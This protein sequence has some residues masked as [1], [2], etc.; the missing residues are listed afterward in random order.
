M[1][2]CRQFCPNFQNLGGE[3]YVFGDI[4]L[5]LK[6]LVKNSPRTKNKVFCDA[7]ER[8]VIDSVAYF[9]PKNR[10]RRTELLK[11]EISG[12]VKPSSDTSLV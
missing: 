9:M 2:V 5:I 11:Q 8:R 1:A 7:T 4:F 6:H 10:L 12:D 3:G